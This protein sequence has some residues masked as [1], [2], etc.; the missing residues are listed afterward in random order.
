[1][2]YETIASMAYYSENKN[3]HVRKVMHTWPQNSIVARF[4]GS[5]A[6]DEVIIIGAHLDSI[7]GFNPNGR[8][9]GADDDGSGTTTILDAFLALVEGNFKPERS[10]EFHWYSGEEMGLWGSQA[11]STEYKKKN[12]KVVGMVQFDMTGFMKKGDHIGIIT[13]YVDKDLTNFLKV[14]TNSYLDVKFKETVCGYACS[15]HASWNRA[16][17][18]SAFPFEGSFPDHS[19]YVHTDKVKVEFNY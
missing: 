5:V 9:P 7:N 4:D 6:P 3:V 14:L 18:R 12:V 16:G 19:P 1:M 11:I 17:Y 8:A 2:L 10:V 15:D 13:D